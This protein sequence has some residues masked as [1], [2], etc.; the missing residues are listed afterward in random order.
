MKAHF[1]AVGVQLVE[2]GHGW[3][4][5]QAAYTRQPEGEDEGVSASGEEQGCAVCDVMS[6][7]TCS[8]WARACLDTCCCWGA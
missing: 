8:C 7:S 6:H 2:L 3:R 5:G 4:L 1:K